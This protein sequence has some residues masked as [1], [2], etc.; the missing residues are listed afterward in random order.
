MND[1]FYT[2]IGINQFSTSMSKNTNE[3]ISIVR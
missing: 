1:N 2:K 3:S